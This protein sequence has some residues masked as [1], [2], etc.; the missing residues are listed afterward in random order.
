MSKK[1]KGHIKIFK[2]V[3]NLFLFFS[4]II[5][6]KKNYKDPEN[7]KSKFKYLNV[8]PIFSVSKFFDNYTTFVRNV[9]LIFFI[10]RSLI[11]FF[12]VSN[13]REKIQVH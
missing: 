9:N 11:P 13:S 1:I 8:D 6:Y 12:S 5:F 2:I 7:F 3:T 4:L 10:S